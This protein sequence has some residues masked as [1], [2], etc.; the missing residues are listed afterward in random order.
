MTICAL[1]VFV[2]LLFPVLVK[3]FTPWH[4]AWYDLSEAENQ[5]L[6][7]AWSGRNMDIV[8]DMHPFEGD[9]LEVFVKKLLDR[10]P[11]GTSVGR[12]RRTASR[13]R[14]PQGGIR[15]EHRPWWF[16]LLYLFAMCFA[17]AYICTTKFQGGIIDV[18]VALPCACEGSW[19]MRCGNQDPFTVRKCAISLIGTV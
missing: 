7:D 19:R 18:G 17:V 15:Q 2:V 6:L 12:M 11:E 10:M 1:L 13:R 3:L 9:E 8:I 16:G 4:E 14:K 5:R